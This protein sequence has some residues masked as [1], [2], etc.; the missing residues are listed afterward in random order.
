MDLS[1]LGRLFS[2]RF[3]VLALS[4]AT[5]IM[6]ARCVSKET[7]GSYQLILSVMTIVGGFC[8]RG[9]SEAVTIS[10][11]KRYDGNAKVILGL[12]LACA[13]VGAMVVAG[14]GW[15][16]AGATPSLLVP[17]LAAA[18]FF[19]FEQLKIFYSS[20]LNGRG[21]VERLF[22]LNFV[23]L[24]GWALL[25]AALILVGQHSL[26]WLLST[27][28]TVS[29]LIT[30]V[31]LYLIFTHLKNTVRDGK[32]V[33]YGIHASAAAM[34][35]GLIAADKVLIGANLSV[36]DVAVWS[37]ALIF[38]EQIKM[39]YGVINQ[40]LVPDMYKAAGI[41][42]GWA[43]LKPRAWKVCLFFAGIGVAGFILFPFVIPL[44][45]SEKY[46][47][48]VPYAKWLWL[49]L[50]LAAPSTY[51]SNLIVAQQKKGYVYLMNVAVPCSAFALYLLF[52]HKGLAGFVIA[53]VAYN[54]LT[55]AFFVG[56][57]IYFLKKDGLYAG[58]NVR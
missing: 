30:V 24:A 48:A 3:G 14:M 9:L 58:Q 54:W 23:E 51:L 29:A 28:F 36:A 41:R 57:F 47:E 45:F 17:F 50:A 8:L 19:P 39:I 15:H 33:T 53:R 22:V 49:S 37:V 32:T 7:Y 35:G 13:M 55:C 34:L 12:Q 6:W 18:F 4:M 40:M 10:A 42:E 52:M 21:H 44:L 46:V 11:A 38:P 43:Y 25:F 56:S 26:T 27:R 5:S 2:W 31:V 20:W 1:K 16:Y